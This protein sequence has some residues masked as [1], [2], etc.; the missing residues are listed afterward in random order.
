MCIVLI[1]QQQPT[2]LAQSCCSTSPS[3]NQLHL[4]QKLATA[5]SFQPDGRRKEDTKLQLNT[6]CT[7]VCHTMFGQYQTAISTSILYSEVPIPRSY[8]TYNCQVNHFQALTSELSATFPNLVA[9][10]TVTTR[11]AVAFTHGCDRT[12]ALWMDMP[13]HQLHIR[14]LHTTAMQAYPGAGT[15]P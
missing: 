7:S 4:Q 15:Q 2:S 12:T 1:H 3:Q 6:S 8:Y 5:T 14:C 9:V 10:C 11:M 13:P